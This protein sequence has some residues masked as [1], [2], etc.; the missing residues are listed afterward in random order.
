MKYKKYDKSDSRWRRV[1]IHPWC[2]D[3]PNVFTQMLYL[4]KD[5]INVN[6][7]KIEHALETGTFEG[8]TAEIFSEH[9]EN[10]YTVEKFVENNSY[11]GE[12]KLID[13]YKKLRKKHPN[14]NFYSGDSPGFIKNVLSKNSDKQFVI[15]LDAHIPGHSPV[16]NE[17]HAIKESSNRKDH[18]ILVDD[19]YDLG[20]HG[21]PTKSQFEAAV[22]N[23]NDN[24]K[25]EYTDYGRKIAI[26]YD[27][28]A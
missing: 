11:N 27:E 3:V 4:Y 2:I 23:I 18:I 16:I 22:K 20:T 6:F 8:D 9:F 17:L 15:L 7:D 24:Y 19:C 13:I 14:I 5:I 28:E 25:I 1:D 12:T 10:V 26:I 21:W